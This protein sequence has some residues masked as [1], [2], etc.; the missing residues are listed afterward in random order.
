[1]S[2][3][4][5]A[6]AAALCVSVFG[7]SGA[8]ANGSSSDLHKAR[9]QPTEITVEFGAPSPG[10]MYAIN[11]SQIRMATGK[12]YK[13][14]LTNLG[15]VTHYVTAPAFDGAIATRSVVVSKGEVRGN[16]ALASTHYINRAT[17]DPMRSVRWIELR[18]G[19]RAEW[20]FIA[21]RSGQYSLECAMPAHTE[22]G[23]TA[24]IVIG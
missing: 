9:A 18:P 10:G 4:L 1:M 14:V 19:G 12:L 8:L 24:Q 5:R 16:F 13:L 7:F 23:M 21:N 2:R 20:V 15:T 17:A 3:H 11:P 6:A 22:A